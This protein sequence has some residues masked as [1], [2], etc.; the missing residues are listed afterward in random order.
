MRLYH[1]ITL[2]IV[3]V[4]VMV[5]ATTTFVAARLMDRALLERF[6][7]EGEFIAR[8][9]SETL[10]MQVIRGEVVPVRDSLRKLVAQNEDIDYIFITD[11]DHQLFAHSFEGGFP[12][13]LMRHLEARNEH[14][15]RRYRKSGSGTIAHIS[16][17]LIEGMDARLHIGMNDS[18]TRG[19]FQRLGGTL[20]LIVAAITLIAVAIAALISRRITEP[21]SRLAHQLERYGQGEPVEIEPLA[22]KS[23][24]RSVAQ[25]YR[26]FTTMVREREQALEAIRT[27]ER[28]LAEAQRIANT[29]NWE[30]D[31]EANTL[32]WS[33]QIYRIFGLQPQQFEAT[34][35]AFLHTLHPEDR[36]RVEEAVAAA[37]E[38]DGPP[39]SIDHRIVLPDG[40]VRIV[41]EQA[42]VIRDDQGRPIRMVGTVQD[43]TERKRAELELQRHRNHLEELVAERTATIAL[44]ARIIDQT[45]DAIA[46][47]DIDGY[48]TS[49]NR[50]AEQLFGLKAEEVL[51]RH[52]ALLYPE[53]LHEK[54]SRQIIPE[55]KEKG[56][57]ELET[58]MVRADGTPFPAHLSLSLLYDENGRPNGIVGYAVDISERKERERALARLTARLQ[59]S[60]RELEAFSYSVS[61]DLRAPL[62]A[63]DG[64]SLALLEDYGD[65]LDT[66][67]RDYIE[68]VRRAAQKMSVLI[69]DLLQLSRITRCE[70]QL[71]PLDLSAMAGRIVADLR[72]AEPER[73]IEVEIAPGLEACGDPTLVGI[74][75]ANLI[76]NAWKFTRRTE[77]ARIEIG[78]REVEGERAF[79]IADNGAGFDMKYA[80]KLFGAFQRL[81]GVDEFEGT[82]IGLAT[83][84]RVLNRHGGRIW[85]EARVGEGATFFFTLPPRGDC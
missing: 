47:T 29:G 28:R 48:L 46:T 70:L 80:G 22:E 58:E 59:A 77:G 26:A 4:A 23:A 83:V 85:T 67:G 12:R 34:Y 13:A 62:R 5:G 72:E 55:L 6:E 60:N 42:E 49:W 24:D 36:P 84:Q 1:K 16:Q 3:G 57:Q 27:N 43:I 38:P 30:W 7:R 10:A 66:T 37:L 75:L 25:L 65:K 81:H 35:E 69:D 15:R 53:H 31:I 78:Q 41:H 56:M 8:S 19:Q 76:G 61:H 33:D 11:F 63:I 82:G 73:E 14:Q 39:Y 74:L 44:Q 64:F 68:R 32:H 20:A 17:P 45:H 52:S 79:Y 2:L 40:T 51:G 9:L 71:Q 54:F 21:L 18:A 50:G